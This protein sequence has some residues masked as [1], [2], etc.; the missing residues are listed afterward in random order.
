MRKTK[1]NED[2]LLDVFESI[3]KKTGQ[4]SFEAWQS[5]VYVIG[6][7]LAVTCGNDC[8][9]IKKTFEMAFE[10]VKEAREEFCA[11]EDALIQSITDN[12]FQ[13]AMGGL[14]MRLGI[15]NEAGGQ[16]FTPFHLSRLMAKI[17]LD[18]DAVWKTILEKGYISVS[19]PSCGSGGNVIAFCNACHDTGIDY[20][21]YVYFECQEISEMTALMCFIQLSL[22]GIAAQI[23]VGDTLKREQRLILKTPVLTMDP[24]WRFRMIRRVSDE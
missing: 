15:G 14:Y 8:I 6:Y 4:S 3:K 11:L 24:V 1:A 19:E 21:Q 9:K 2:K 17:D 5:F 22:M 20:Q 10:V 16:F 12:K 18:K 7:T 23:I 13:D